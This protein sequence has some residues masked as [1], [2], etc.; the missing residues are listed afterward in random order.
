MNESF[1]VDVSKLEKKNNVY[2]LQFHIRSGRDKGNLF[3][4]KKPESRSRG[5]EP[6]T[7]LFF[8]LLEAEDELRLPLLTGYS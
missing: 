2:R 6:S 5:C 3:S 8:V 7:A 1:Q 4:R